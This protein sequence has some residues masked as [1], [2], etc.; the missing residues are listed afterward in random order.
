MTVLTL[1][2]GTEFRTRSSRRFHLV[3]VTSD[4]PHR[5]TSRDDELAAVN[6]Y[7]ALVRRHPSVTVWLVDRCGRLVRP[8]PQDGAA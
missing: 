1:P 7:W 2:D 8:E 4:G 6:A 5:I 3:A